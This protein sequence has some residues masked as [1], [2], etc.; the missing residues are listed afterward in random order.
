MLFPSI[1]HSDK[2]IVLS[3]YLLSYPSISISSRRLPSS[4]TLTVYLLL[5][6]PLLS[7]HQTNKSLLHSSRS[8]VSN[9]FD[10]LLIHKKPLLCSQTAGSFFPISSNACG[11]LLTLTDFLLSSSPLPLHS[12]NHHFHQIS[13]LPSVYESYSPEYL[14]PLT[15]SRV[16]VDGGLLHLATTFPASPQFFVFFLVRSCKHLTS[17][18]SKARLPNLF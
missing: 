14:S 11:W 7:P 13:T 16:P 2:T 10:S 12:T 15:T 5:A 17:L 1:Y 6:Q 3:I 8:R 18:L 9:L 4:R